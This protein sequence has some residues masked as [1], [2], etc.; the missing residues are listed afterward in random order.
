[1]HFTMHTIIAIL[2]EW[3]RRHFIPVL[4]KKEKK[5]NKVLYI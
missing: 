2:H 4:T 5:K 1:M 3:F